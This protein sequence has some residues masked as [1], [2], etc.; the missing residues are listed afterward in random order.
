MKKPKDLILSAIVA[1]DTNRVIGKD[2][3]IPWKV[4]SD[5]KYFKEKTMGGTM[6]MGRKTYESIG[7]PLPGRSTIILTKQHGYSA[8]GCIVCHSVSDVFRKCP[9]GE[10]FVIG[11]QK[12]Y[13]LFFD[14]LNLVYL[15]RV[16]A[17][18]E[19]DTFFP[20]LKPS[21]WI[22]MRKL[23]GV[24]KDED[25]FDFAFEVYMSREKYSVSTESMK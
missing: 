11:G 2:N 12:I 20:E 25:E 3:A 9:K 14:Y 6:I 17:S 8:P 23:P 22:L 19:G 24:K 21:E 1:T 10:V 4:P 13:E 16:K 5:L 7:K 18:V 15:T